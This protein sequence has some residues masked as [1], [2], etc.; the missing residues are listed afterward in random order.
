MTPPSVSLFYLTL[1]SIKSILPQV[2]TIIFVVGIE[3]GGI[4]G[5]M[6]GGERFGTNELF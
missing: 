5:G 6:G 1:V 3:R 2:G 4:E